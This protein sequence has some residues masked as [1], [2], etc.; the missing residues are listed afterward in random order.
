ML[1]LI[2][3]PFGQASPRSTV[4]L[5]V[6]HFRRASD[7]VR[8]RIIDALFKEFWVRSTDDGQELEIRSVP[9]HP[10]K[11]LVDRQSDGDETKNHPLLSEMGGIWAGGPHD[12]AVGDVNKADLVGALG[13]EPRTKGL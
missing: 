9:Q 7:A 4:F 13:L 5:T 11:M 3:F 10:V 12:S 2:A 8:R 1:W 6:P